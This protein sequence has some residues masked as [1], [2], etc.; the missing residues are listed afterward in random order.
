MTAVRS[1]VVLWRR[2]PVASMR[3]EQAMPKY[4]A[5]FGAGA[6]LG[7]DDGRYT[8]PIASRLYDALAVFNPDGWGRLEA[9]VAQR[10]RDDF[11]AAM[12]TVNPHVMAPLQRAM[13]AYFFQFVPRPENLYVEI[14]R[15]IRARP[16]PGAWATLNY[17]RLGELALGSQ[18]IPLVVGGPPT[19]AGQIELCLPHGCCH[20]FCDSVTGL[21][22]AVSFAGLQVTTNGPVRQ[23]ADP[24]EHSRRLMTDAFPPVMCYFEPAKRTTSGDSFIQGQKARFRQLV[25]EAEIIAVV[26]VRVRSV[27][28]HIWGPLATT[29]AHLVYCAG[30]S[31]AAECRVWA[32]KERTGRSDIILDGYFADSLGNLIAELGL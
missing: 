11:E 2:E 22:S 1:L 32:E 16:W 12:T 19:R 8:P 3:I 9:A 13:A 28:T 23:I 24:S 27:D 21:A 25:A 6:S 14:A 5:F 7:S 30:P 18:G 31:G 15:R 26:G 4:L 17:E 29:S 20:L 10:F